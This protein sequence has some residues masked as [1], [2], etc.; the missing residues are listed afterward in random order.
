PARPRE[1]RP[2]RSPDRGGTRD[3]SSELRR[4]GAGP[5]RG[6]RRTAN[7]PAGRAHRGA[8]PARADPAR[9]GPAGA[10]GQP[11]DQV[12]ADHDAGPRAWPRAGRGGRTPRVRRG[13]P[14]PGPGWDRARAL[15]TA[16]RLLLGYDFYRRR[17]EGAPPAHVPA[18]RAALVFAR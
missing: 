6:Q 3:H 15:I 2:G 17:H 1:G 4:V 18:V 8:A 16:E 14:R 10:G 12:L 7:A 13:A 11:A 5:A 9:R